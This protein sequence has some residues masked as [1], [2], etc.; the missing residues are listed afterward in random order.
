MVPAVFVPLTALPI[1]TNGKVDR[2]A[3]PAP[4]AIPVERDGAGG[5]ARTL[6]EERVAEMVATL[7]QVQA[8]GREE[9]FFLLGGHSLLGAQLL[10]RVRDSF[11]VDL[12]LRTLFDL[13]SVAGLSSEIEQRLMASLAAMSDAEAERLLA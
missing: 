8:V 13:P 10:V 5:S 4:S 11:G 9:N 1:T 6:I 2:Q 7:L 3:L 12:S